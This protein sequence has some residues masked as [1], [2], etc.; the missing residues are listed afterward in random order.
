[1]HADIMP[2][3]LYKLYAG[4]HNPRLSTLENEYGYPPFQ[5]IFYLFN[6]QILKVCL[7]A[8]IYG[9]LLFSLLYCLYKI[10]NQ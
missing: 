4:M 8:C 7:N 6:I 10:N 5:H 3:V 2:R 9:K 1:M